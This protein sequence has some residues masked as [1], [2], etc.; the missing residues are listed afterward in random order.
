[1]S[2]ARVQRIRVWPI[3]IALAVASAVGLLAALIGDGAWD[4]LSWICLGA[5][6]VA[7]AWSFRRGR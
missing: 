1:V 6:I 5:P 3:P 4:A 7:M 2:G